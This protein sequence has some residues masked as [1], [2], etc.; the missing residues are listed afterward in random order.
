MYADEFQHHPQNLR[1][2]A[3]VFRVRATLNTTSADT[4][5]EFERI[6]F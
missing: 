1:S 3:N 4:G 2:H 6:S 5:I